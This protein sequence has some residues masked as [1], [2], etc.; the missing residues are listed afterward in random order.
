MSLMLALIFPLD[1]LAQISKKKFIFHSNYFKLLDLDKSGNW[2]LN[3]FL[4]SWSS[5]FFILPGLVLWDSPNIFSSSRNNN[6]KNQNKRITSLLITLITN[7]ASINWYSMCS[8][9][10]RCRKISACNHHQWLFFFYQNDINMFANN[11]Y[12]IKTVKIKKNIKKNLTIPKLFP[13]SL[14]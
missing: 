1:S 11:I 13:N 12:N 4:K 2:V 6:E 7:I 3:S 9:C 14:S 8:C 5:C 10:T